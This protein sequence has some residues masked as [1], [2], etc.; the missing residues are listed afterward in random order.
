MVTVA[1][2]EAFGT[3]MS[4]MPRFWHYGPEDVA[5]KVKKMSAA[6]PGAWYQDD[7]SGY[8][9]SVAHLHQQEWI[10]TCC[11]PVIGDRVAE[12]RMWWKD[13]PLLGP[14]LW[15]DDAAFLYKKHGG[16]SSGE[17]FTAKDGT[18][19]NAARILMCVAAAHGWT[20]A[21]AV[22]KLGVKWDFL[23]QGDDT[24]LRVD[25]AAFDELAYVETSL[26]LGYT[27]KLAPGCVFLMKYYTDLGQWYPLISRIFQQTVFNEY[28]GEMLELEL[29]SLAAR[30]TG[31]E[32]HP[33]LPLLSEMLKTSELARV[34]GVTS[35]LDV[36]RAAVNPAVLAAVEAKANEKP[37]IAG[38]F[39]NLPASRIS[40]I[41][42]GMLG[43]DRVTVPQ[44]S[45]AAASAMALRLADWMG[46]KAADREDLNDP[47]LAAL[48]DGIKIGTGEPETYNDEE[49]T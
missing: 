21:Q 34:F 36:Q 10:T 38:R 40:D 18:G 15:A 6:I 48:L 39:R 17:F 4:R 9:Q 47:Q 43:E 22:L 11:A 25:P 32:L 2:A 45:Q 42:A 46:T 27:A 24:V 41:V 33:Y 28:G 12:F 19:I 26:A 7:I 31:V 5:V 35:W 44:V 8:D 29:F 49:R 23:V 1:G 37:R 30:S 3:I 13:L 16:T 14:K 20:L